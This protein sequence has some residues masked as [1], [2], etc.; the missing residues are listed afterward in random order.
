MR[1]ALRRAVLAVTVAATLAVAPA[2]WAV[3]ETFDF[4]VDAA[5]LAAD[6]HTIVVSGTYTCGP[7]DTTGGVVDLTV[8]QGRTTGFGYAPI[9]KCDGSAQTY[10][11]DVVSN[12]NRQFKRGA[13][14]VTASGYVQ[15]TAG[16]LQTTRI[17]N[18]RIT[19]RRR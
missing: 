3:D 6:G 16:G 4:T 11:T 5:R 1:T 10:E 18:Q 8:R 9:L 2:A 19:I 12:S 17:D 15:G 14:W 13:A 7:F